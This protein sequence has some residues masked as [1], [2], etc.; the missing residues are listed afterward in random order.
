[1][2]PTVNSYERLQPASLS[3]YWRNWGVDHRGVTTRVSSET[4]DHARIEHRMADG[5]ANT[6]TMVASILQAALL[7]YRN[8]YPLQPA[9]T[10]DC[11]E[12]HDAEDGVPENLG[13]ALDALISDTALVTAVGS[14]LVGNL[15]T[16]K[17]YEIDSTAGLSGSA[18]RDYY[19]YYL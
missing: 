1:M 11:L 16:I 12:N 10:S 9:E 18:L 13:D 4:G 7:G 3:G 8:N 17:R 5:A 6:Y 14:E 15:E 19:L 2:A